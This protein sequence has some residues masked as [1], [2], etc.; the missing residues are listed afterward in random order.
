MLPRI[1]DFCVKTWTRFS[2]RDKRLF[3]VIEVEIMRVDCIYSYTT[4]RAM[5][6]LKA[7]STLCASM[8]VNECLLLVNNKK[9]KCKACLY[10]KNHFQN[11]S[12]CLPILYRKIMYVMILNEY[13]K[14]VALTYKLAKWL[15][16][17]TQP[18]TCI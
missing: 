9:Q 5:G 7:N 1:L 14:Q 18:P 12:Q 11:F 3:E 6:R 16:K 15:K 4:G 10:F 8:Y 2:Y 17:K 13:I